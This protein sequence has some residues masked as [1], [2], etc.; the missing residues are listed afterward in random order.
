MSSNVDSAERHE[1]FEIGAPG[2]SDMV[3]I[4]PTKAIRELSLGIRRYVFYE[5]YAD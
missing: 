1:G 5:T 2:A 3:N 4:G